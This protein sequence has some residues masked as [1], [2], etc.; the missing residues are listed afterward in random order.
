MADLL[1]ESIRDK[2]YRLLKATTRRTENSHQPVFVS[3]LA[4]EL[5]LNEGEVQGAFLYLKGKRWIDTFNIDYTARINAV[6]HVAAEVE[7]KS[8]VPRRMPS[9]LGSSAAP[10]SSGAC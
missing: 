4:S 3:E 7:R 8:A 10:E 6:G 5:N 1:G 9:H 2:A